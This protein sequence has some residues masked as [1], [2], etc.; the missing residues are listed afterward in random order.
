MQCVVNIT[1]TL[2]SDVTFSIKCF[3][4]CTSTGTNTT[5][6]VPATTSAAAAAA[7]VEMFSSE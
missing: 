6:T 5:T 4:I 1:Q 7:A 2:V 3:N